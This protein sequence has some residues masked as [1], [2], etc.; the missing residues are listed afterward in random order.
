MT[1]C[2]RVF[3]LLKTSEKLQKELAYT[4]GTGERNVSYWKDRGTD[5]PAKLIAP[6]ADF[7]GVS[8]EWLLTGEDNRQPGKSISGGMAGSA[9]AQATNIGS[10]NARGGDGSDGGA[11]PIGDDEAELLRIY[12]A[13]DVRRRHRLMAHAFA[14]EEEPPRERNPSPID[15]Q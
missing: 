6:I 2:Q 10:N 11:R 5:P 3:A 4:I 15:V 9:L 14:L 12:G 1:I 13:L 8:V 7:F